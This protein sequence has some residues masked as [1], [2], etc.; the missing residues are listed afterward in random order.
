MA[1]PLNLFLVWTFFCLFFESSVGV[2]IR[3]IDGE[4]AIE[5]PIHRAKH[6][7]QSLLEFV[8]SKGLLKNGTAHQNSHLQDI[9]KKLKMAPAPVKNETLAIFKRFD[10]DFYALIRIGKP[11]NLT[12]KF[13]IDTSWADTWV[14]SNNC[15]E[16][17][18]DNKDK[19]NAKRSN[20]SHPDGRNFYLDLGQG[21]FG[22]NLT[23]IL[24]IDTFKFAHMN[25]TNVTFAEVSNIPWFMYFTRYDG[26]LGMSRG[27]ENLQG[28]PLIWRELVRQNKIKRNMF[29]LYLNRDPTSDRAGSI[30]IGAADPHHY[31]GSAS[32]KVPLTGD[33]YW[34]FD[35]KDLGFTYVKNKK[36]KRKPVLEFCKDSCL[37][38]LA[39]GGNIIIGPTAAIN[40]IHQ[41]I[42]AQPFFFGFYRVPCE[43]IA[44]LPELYFSFGNKDIVLYGEQYIQQI[45]YNGYVLC[46]STFAPQDGKEW[47]FG[48]PLL[49]KYYTIYDFDQN[50]I[51][52]TDYK[53]H[54]A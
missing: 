50:T 43:N 29:S 26:I 38:K 3:E 1:L 37:A 54:E 17:T 9:F 44:K 8:G 32:A 45:F 35:I 18:C 36:K 49:S 14:V 12:Y 7:A 16:W 2:T 47:I 25:A 31:N 15:K 19:Y 4:K 41:L 39:S 27:T 33:K 5:L 52:I 20:T 13:V 6:P 34:Q 23:G 40:Q 30:L 11:A 53:T 10:S 28:A 21:T 42:G 51:S 46:L 48:I 24:A 22:G